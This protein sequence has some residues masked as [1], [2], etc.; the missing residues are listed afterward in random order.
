[1]WMTGMSIDGGRTSTRQSGRSIS[2]VHMLMLLTRRLHNDGKLTV[3]RS[4]VAGLA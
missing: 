3:V 2:F 1:M 4:H